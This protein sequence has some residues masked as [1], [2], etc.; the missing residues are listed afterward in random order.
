MA[1][2]I[3]DRR[4]KNR[5]KLWLLLGIQTND[6]LRIYIR[7]GHGIQQSK[8]ARKNGFGG[9]AVAAIVHLILDNHYTSFKY[10][11]VFVEA[12]TKV[13]QPGI[14]GFITETAT[15]F[16]ISTFCSSP[17]NLMSAFAKKS[18]SKNIFTTSSSNVP[19]EMVNRCK[20]KI[21]VV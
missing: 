4:V 16:E 20:Q 21:K 6:I 18:N 3:R 10:K 2:A 9:G 19:T 13:F 17:K 15:T 11:L 8:G 7:V 1:Q 5:K 14:E 12:I